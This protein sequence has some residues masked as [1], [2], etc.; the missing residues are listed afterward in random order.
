M[1]SVGR[2]ILICAH[3]RK[4]STLLLRYYTEM[5]SS[6]IKQ[7]RL[8]M[9]KRQEV[10]KKRGT[11]ISLHLFNN[12]LW[13]NNCIRWYIPFSKIRT[14]MKTPFLLSLSNFK[15]IPV[16]EYRGVKQKMRFRSWERCYCGWGICRTRFYKYYRGYFLNVTFTQSNIW[17]LRKFFTYY[18]YTILNTPSIKLTGTKYIN[19]R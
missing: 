2:V 13:S 16:I 18:F 7:K 14:K 4:C 8:K 6:S 19:N 3:V 11:K 17:S 5:K 9:K 1:N 15:R 12:L 10:G